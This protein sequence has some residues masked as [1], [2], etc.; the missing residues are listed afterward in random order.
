MLF[1]RYEI[2]LVASKTDPEFGIRQDTTT[3]YLY[4]AVGIPPE[5][6]TA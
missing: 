2:L 5:L 4:V 6:S 3:I 1:S